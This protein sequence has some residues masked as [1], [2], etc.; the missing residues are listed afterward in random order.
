MKVIAEITI[1][2]FRGGESA[3]YNYH[4]IQILSK[5]I[6]RLS[7]SLYDLVCF[8]SRMPDLWLNEPD[9]IVL[10]YHQRDAV[11][12]KIHHSMLFGSYH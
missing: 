8:Q 5:N 3:L 10:A 4:R 7:L 1:Y 12:F 2:I 6:L 9:V 11:V